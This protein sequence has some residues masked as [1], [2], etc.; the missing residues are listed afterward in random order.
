MYELTKRI[1]TSFLLIIILISMFTYNYIFISC[2]IIIASIV[3]IELNNLL[4][5][6]F[7]SSYYRI[8]INALSLIYIF[9]FV[10]ISINS[11]YSVDTKIIWM[12]SI[13]ICIMSDIGG[14]IFGKIFKGPRITK[15]SPNKTFSGMVGAYFLSLTILFFYHFLIDD[16]NFYKYLIITLIVST[17]SQLGDIFISYIKRKAKVKNTSDILPGHGGLLDRV[18]GIIFGIPI[19]LNLSIII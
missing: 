7:K 8:L 18:D 3:W 14:F 15:I 5:K 10:W 2:L 9:Y 13:I 17:I 19:G 1:L 16:N 11:I 6:I 12:Y 4:I